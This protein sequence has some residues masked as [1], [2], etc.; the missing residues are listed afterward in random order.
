MHKIARP[1]TPAP[2]NLAG[3]RG[4]PV[5]RADPAVPDA[6]F[7]DSG[8]GWLDSTSG[9]LA[10]YNPSYYL[11]VRPGDRGTQTIIR[12]ESGEV[13]LSGDPIDILDEHLSR[14]HY[15]VGYIGYGFGRHCDPGF[16]PSGK[17]PDLDFPELYF[18][19]FEQDGVRETPRGVTQKRGGNARRE[20]VIPE[21]STEH[22]SFISKVEQARRYIERGDIYQ[23]NLSRALSCRV[24]M[25][26]F[27][28]LDSL[29]AVQP[30]PFGC[31][32]GFPGFSLLSGSM[33]LFLRRTGNRLVTRPIKGTSRR[34][35][36]PEE[37]GALVRALVGSEKERAENL[38]IVDLMRNDL[39][40]VC[41]QGT[42]TVNA[43]CEVETYTTLH[44]LVSEVEGLSMPG[45]TPGDIIRATFPPGSVTGTPKIKAMQVIDELEPHSRGPYCGAIGIFSPDGDFTL[46]V[47]IRI[48]VTTAQ[49]LLY[50]V[51]AGI[52]WDS[53]P[54][55]EF[56][57]TELK[58]QA[59]LRALGGP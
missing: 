31:F 46:S 12:R 59:L 35:G 3:E 44:Q 17:Q 8:G 53:D 19:F 2:S 25:P 57:E 58:A 37:D 18:M 9:S 48:A 5:N 7:V 15:A 20:P 42:V 47:A 1:E 28:C 22:A 43:L 45:I 55:L 27:E 52:V 29:L 23:A 14:G 11:L 33:E 49:R 21:S 56:E 13:A 10:F 30:V 24:D 26:P 50:W 16:A 34:G 32:M 41:E 40:K 38:M 51:G 4:D 6:L 36:T 39:S 54:C